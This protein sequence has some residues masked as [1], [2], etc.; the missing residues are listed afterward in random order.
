MQRKISLLIIF[1]LLL[2]STSNVFAVAQFNQNNIESS[3]KIY[4][5][6]IEDYLEVTIVEAS[7]SGSRVQ[8]KDSKNN[9]IY[10]YSYNINEN[11]FYNHITNEKEFLDEIPINYDT[12]T[13][14]ESDD[15]NIMADYVFCNIGDS[16]NSNFSVSVRAITGGVILTAAA[17]VVKLAAA[18]A[19][20]IGV[21]VGVVQSVG[22]SAFLI[23]ANDIKEAAISGE[24]G[25]YAHF[26]QHFKCKYMC[27]FDPFDGN[28]CF[29]GY[30]L[31]SITYKGL[32]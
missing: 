19:V 24:W 20:Y 18:I 13:G 3:F 17:I 12:P 8:G 1:I 4:D 2:V 31:D 25:R 22:I 32:H 21:S 29:Y 15:F 28:V 27:A 9:I 11:S 14:L 5:E 16:Y 7:E 10:D 6:T 23:G 30:D 26:T